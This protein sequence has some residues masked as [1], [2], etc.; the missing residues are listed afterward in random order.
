[1]IDLKKTLYHLSLLYVSPSKMPIFF[2]LEKCIKANGGTF[3]QELQEYPKF[4]ND[5]HLI[6]GYACF[7]TFWK[8]NTVFSSVSCTT[9]DFRNFCGSYCAPNACSVSTLN[10]KGNPL[11]KEFL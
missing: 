4:H 3:E 7:N 2:R 11:K 1:M 9:T 8:I 10:G 6:H 5:A